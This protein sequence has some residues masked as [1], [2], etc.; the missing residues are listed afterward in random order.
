MEIKSFRGNRMNVGEG[1]RMTCE[2]NK[3][4][5]YTGDER[6]VGWMKCTYKK[7]HLNIWVWFENK[8]NTTRRNALNDN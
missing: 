7:C 1:D 6:L 4:V 5:G 3:R 2:Y 8:T